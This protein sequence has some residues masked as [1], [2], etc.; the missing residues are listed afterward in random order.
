M[1]SVASLVVLSSFLLVAILWLAGVIQDAH[2]SFIARS[3]EE[4]RARRRRPCEHD[5]ERERLNSIIREQRRDEYDRTSLRRSLRQIEAYNDALLALDANPAD[6]ELLDIGEL[7]LKRTNIECPL[8]R[9]DASL[10]VEC[11]SCSTEMHLECAQEM[12]KSQC[13]TLGCG[14]S[15]SSRDTARYKKDRR[16]N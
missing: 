12:S 11:S 15:L 16:L 10:D 13:P 3:H 8:C 5:A 14:K 7:T 6:E 2:E 1:L 9:E 4:R